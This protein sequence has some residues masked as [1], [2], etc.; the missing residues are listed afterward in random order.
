MPFAPP[1]PPPSCSS[2]CT[3]RRK[4][5]LRNA[6]TI[7]TGEPDLKGPFQGPRCGWEDS[8]EMCLKDMW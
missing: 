2:N 5:E 8:L 7:W 3:D 4:G 6:Y 1:P